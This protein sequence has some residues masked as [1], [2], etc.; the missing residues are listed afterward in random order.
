LGHDHLRQDWPQPFY[1]G[2]Y[3][4]YWGADLS[5]DIAGPAAPPT[6][7]L[8][9]PTPA[10]EPPPPPPAPAQPLIREYSWPQ[11]N[12][13]APEFAIVLKDGTVHRALAVCRQDGLLTYV[14]PDGSGS[15]LEVSAVDR[16]A[17]RRANSADLL[18]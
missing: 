12:S 9:Q 15:Q 17:T 13:A 2:G 14:T 10:P 8:M 6:I 7:L 11:S 3:G 18:R 1:A 16:E 4:G 5:A